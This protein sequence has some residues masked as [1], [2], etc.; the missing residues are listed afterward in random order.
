MD[1]FL[2]ISEVKEILKIKSRSTLKNLA[3][4]GELVP[5]IIGKMKRYRM[6]DIQKI[7]DK[8]DGEDE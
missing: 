1:E 2:T 3:E 6:K 4:T 7:L 8:G 5:I